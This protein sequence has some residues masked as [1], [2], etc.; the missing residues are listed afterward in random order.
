M[1]WWQGNN[2]FRAAELSEMAR[3]KCERITRSRW[4]LLTVSLENPDDKR[5]AFVVTREGYPNYRRVFVKSKDVQKHIYHFYE[6]LS[7]NGSGA[8][9][10][11]FL[12]SM[13]QVTKKQ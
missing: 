11:I 1:V 9:N 6:N 8:P 5:S 13:N 2:Q 7:F 12:D 4:D 10:D 3:M